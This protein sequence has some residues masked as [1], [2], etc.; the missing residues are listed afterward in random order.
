[1]LQYWTLITAQTTDS[2]LCTH[3]MI[4]KQLLLLTVVSS[5]QYLL[6][7]SYM[8]TVVKTSLLNNNFVPLKVAWQ[9]LKS[10]NGCLSDKIQKDRDKQSKNGQPT[11]MR[12]EL[13]ALVLINICQN[14]RCCHD[15]LQEKIMLSCHLAVINVYCN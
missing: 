11:L 7:V 14:Y 8:Y 4:I 10:R 1:M 13:W 9:Q 12:T 6:T 15:T 2:A 5:L 3:G